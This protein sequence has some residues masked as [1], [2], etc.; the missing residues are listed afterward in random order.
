MDAWSAIAR[1]Y[2]RLTMMIGRG[3]TRVVDDAGAVQL[4]QV[5]FG[6]LETRDKTPRVGEYGFAFNP[7]SGTDAVV[8]FIAGN[9]D[10]GVIIGTNH[11][12]SRLKDLQPGEV[13]IYDDQGRWVWLKRNSIEVEAGGKPIDVKNADVVT[14]NASSKVELNTPLLKVN[15]DITATGTVTGDTDVKAGTISLKTHKHGGVTAGGAQTGVPV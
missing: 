10:N 8:A 6:P 12:D 3:E 14:V 1:L 7:P 4:V 5:V 13:A 15:G 9:R 2:N 11:K